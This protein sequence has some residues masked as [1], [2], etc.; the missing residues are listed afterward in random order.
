[1]AGFA[2][3]TGDSKGTAYAAWQGFPLDVVPVSGKTG[4]AQVGAQEEGKGDTSLFVG[5]Y[6]ANAPKY[7]VA[8]V[9]EQGGMGAQTSAPIVRRVIEAMT[10]I[11]STNPV[12]A[13][14]SGQD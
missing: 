2:G 9:V 12:Q 7:V 4:T 13:L 6:P 11:Q 3:V 1:M 14:N 8:A 5:F 10:H